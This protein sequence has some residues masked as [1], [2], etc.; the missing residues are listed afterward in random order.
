MPQPPLCGEF[1]PY[2]GYCSYCCHLREHP[3]DV[4][5]WVEYLGCP[6]VT[7]RFLAENPKKKRK[8]C[9][10]QEIM[11]GKDDVEEVD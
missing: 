4:E 2:E 3:Q 1:C 11:T 7:A 6:K 8:L 9:E 5:T 10:K